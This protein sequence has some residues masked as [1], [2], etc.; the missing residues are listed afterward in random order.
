MCQSIKTIFFSFV[1]LIFFS[2]TN[3][4]AGQDSLINKKGNTI[5]TRFKTPVGFER[6]SL[7]PNSFAFYLQNLPLKPA[8]TKVKLYNGEEKWKDCYDAVVDLDIGNKDLEQCADAVIRLRAEYFY[9]QKRYDDIHFN[10]TSGFNAEYTKWMQGQRISVK[11]DIC[12]WHPSKA[13]SNTYKDF[14]NF[15]D[16]VFNYAGTISLSESLKEKDVRDIAIGDVFVRA[17]SPGHAVIVVDVAED[18]NGKKMFLLAQSYMPA[19]DIQI[20]KNGGNGSISPWYSSE[21]TD[22]LIT[23]EYTFS[24]DNLKTW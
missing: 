7:E 8:G 3:H 14:R 15:M 18:K 19:Q 6:K 9:G 12:T 21:V 1:L 2:C 13:P 16:V 17:G 22:E 20:L 10:F 11:D 24:K 4:S 23:P 5:K